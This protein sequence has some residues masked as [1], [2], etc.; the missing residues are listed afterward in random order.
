MTSFLSRLAALLTTE[1]R[2]WRKKTVWVL[3]GARYHTSIATRTIMKQLGVTYIISAPYS[4][5]SAPAELCF[6]YFKQKQINPEH[7]RVGKK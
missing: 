7:E 1:D 2:D 6:A 5:D 4:Y 3:D